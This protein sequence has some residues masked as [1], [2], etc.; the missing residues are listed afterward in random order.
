MIVRKKKSIARLHRV[1]QGHNTKKM[2]FDIVPEFSISIFSITQ[3]LPP[4]IQ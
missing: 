4:S 3:V 1:Q 2:K